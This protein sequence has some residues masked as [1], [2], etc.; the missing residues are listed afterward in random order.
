[1]Q[2]N[3]LRK[4]CKWN[5]LIYVH[6]GVNKNWALCWEGKTIFHQNDVQRE[7]NQCQFVV[8][9][10]V[11]VM[12]YG[13]DMHVDLFVFN[14]IRKRVT[15][16][17]HSYIFRYVDRN[18]LESDQRKALLFETFF[19]WMN[20]IEGIPIAILNLIVFASIII[21]VKSPSGACISSR[22]TKSRATTSKN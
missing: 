2:D 16:Y 17:L 18:I 6:F 10:L 15:Y 5:Y 4:K 7:P 20:F 13:K 22:S 3:S 1:M 12:I 19:V 21:I 8:R 11:Q 9:L 14:F